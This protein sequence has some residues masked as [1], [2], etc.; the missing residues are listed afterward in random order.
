MQQGQEQ[1][2]TTGLVRLSGAGE[3]R[4]WI[5]PAN[6][7][8]PDV[9]R[10]MA[11]AL[12]SG[13]TVLGYRPP[14]LRGAV[15][16]AYATWQA[17]ADD[18]LAQLPEGAPVIGI[19][20]SLGAIL[21]LYAAQRAPQRFRGLVLIDP[22]IFGQRLRWIIRVLQ[23][24]GRGQQMPLARAAAR[25]RERFATPQEAH[26]RWR[27]R[28]VFAEFDEAALAAYVQTGLTETADGDWQL[29]WP[30]GWEA[31]IF[32]TSP[33]DG[34][35]LL[36]QVRVP[37]LIL[38]GR[39]SNLI[40]AALWRR[41]QRHAPRATYE[42]IAAGHLLPFEVPHEVAYHIDTWLTQQFGLMPKVGDGQHSGNSK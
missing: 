41:M 18:M 33:T 37:L 25:R 34:W 1:N 38:R 14:P 26:E 16:A 6:G 2:E 22:V 36:P 23:R 10:T 42:E 20:H 17:L 32:A 7:F 4:L 8:S 39:H 11:E 30:R 27:V 19:G 5:A 3:Q 28:Q 29:A 35:A 15:T 24:L 40:G 13:V 9:Y 21:T 12:T 31:H